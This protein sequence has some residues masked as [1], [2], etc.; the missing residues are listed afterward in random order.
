MGLGYL[1]FD[2]CSDLNRARVEGT[3][4]PGEVSHVSGCR[5][6]SWTCGRRCFSKRQVRAY[7]AR[8]QVRSIEEVKEFTPYL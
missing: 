6:R 3:C 4:S 7:A 1:E 5:L 2:S 8:I